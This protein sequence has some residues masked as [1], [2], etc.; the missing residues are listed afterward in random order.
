MDDVTLTK[1]LDTPW[2]LPRPPAVSVCLFVCLFVC[3]QKLHKIFIKGLCLAI[4]ESFCGWQ[5]F[6]G[7][8]TKGQGQGLRLNE[9]VTQRGPAGVI[10]RVDNSVLGRSVVNLK[11]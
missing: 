11:R 7:F 9:E 4:R 6:W 3:E 5:P 8:K 10:A 2:W 1:H